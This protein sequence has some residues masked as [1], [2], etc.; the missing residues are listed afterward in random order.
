MRLPW[1]SDVA[2]H[3]H[4][5]GEAPAVAAYDVRAAAPAA[6]AVV[7][8][9]ATAAAERIGQGKCKH[10]ALSPTAGGRRRDER[11]DERHPVVVGLG[12]GSDSARLQHFERGHALKLIEPAIAILVVVGQPEENLYERHVVG[13]GDASDVICKF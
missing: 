8:M 7:L 3:D 6:A 9:T 1:P 2:R 4:P 11:L 5:N 12:L 13:A 10:L